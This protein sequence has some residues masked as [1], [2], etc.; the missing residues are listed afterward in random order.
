VHSHFVHEHQPLG[1][2]LC[3]HH[4]PPGGPQELVSLCGASSPLYVE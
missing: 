4:H 1:V 3:G 2:D